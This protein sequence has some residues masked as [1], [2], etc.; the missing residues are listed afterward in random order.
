MVWRGAFGIV[1]QYCS[2]SPGA[3]P[4]II[5]MITATPGRS[6]IPG[7]GS[8]DLLWKWLKELAVNVI[9]DAL[10]ELTALNQ[11][12]S[13]IR[14]SQELST[15]SQHGIMRTPGWPVRACHR[16]NGSSSC[17]EEMASHD[18]KNTATPK[19]PRKCW[20]FHT[21]TFRS[22]SGKAGKLGQKA[23]L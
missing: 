9:A 10:F 1:L 14:L 4:T 20:L 5:V 13:S 19:M 2:N 23:L 3:Y 11:T 8:R 12:A 16:V 18:Q 21:E 22:F 6:N 7:A 17:H 15:G